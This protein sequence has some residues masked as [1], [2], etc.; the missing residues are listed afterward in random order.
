MV[1]CSVSAALRRRLLE[2]RMA[3]FSVRPRAGSD[4]GL[5]DTWT[6]M[7][8]KNTGLLVTRL[9]IHMVHNTVPQAVLKIFTAPCCTCSR[10][11]ALER[12]WQL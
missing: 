11:A 12:T 8:K 1:R 10:L 2:Y 4:G 7:E 5:G 9:G 6:R 3:L